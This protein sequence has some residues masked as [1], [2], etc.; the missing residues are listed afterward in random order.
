VLLLGLCGAA[1]F[2]SP[3]FSAPGVAPRPELSATP[4]PAQVGEAVTFDGSESRGDGQG[5]SVTGYEWDLDGD[6]V[7]ERA[8]GTTATT[9]HGY[10]NPQTVTARLR[11][12][13]EDS[14]IA[15]TSVSLRINAPPKA[16]FIYQPSRP[17]VG[18]R[19]VLSS[20]SSDPDGAIPGTGYTWDLDGDR[21]FG[22]ATGETVTTSFP[23]QGKNKVRLLVTD[24]DGATDKVAHKIR[25]IAEARPLKLMKPFPTVRLRGAIVSGGA[26]EIDLL[27]VNGPKGAKASVQCRGGSCPFERRKKKL[28]KR[29][30][31]FPEIRGRLQP[32]VVIDVRVTQRRRIGK[33]TRFKLRD[34][35]VPKREDRC[36]EPGRH[37]PVDC[38]R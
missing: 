13:D 12:T 23:K 36:L 20:T 7:F 35:K 15:E 10:A 17:K 26:T 4:S 19:V 29:R 34:A 16:G 25:V 18:R 30:L 28:G 9:V 1:L 27:A 37:R 11:I 32:G 22:D 2:A 31:T 24:A 8:T 14:D 6:G 5:A 38:P 3:A 21:Q 33:F